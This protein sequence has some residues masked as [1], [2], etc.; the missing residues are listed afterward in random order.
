MARI[1]FIEADGRQ[2]VVEAQDGH[3]LMESAK[4]NGVDGILA[5]CGGNCAC[6]TCR[7]YVGEDWQ[8]RLGER[9]ELEEAT[10]ELREPP[11]PHERLSCQITVSEALDG[12]VVNLPERQF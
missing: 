8:P 6:G 12:L 2:H 1:T 3:S 10:L 9:S 5:D 11:G 4:K 7:I